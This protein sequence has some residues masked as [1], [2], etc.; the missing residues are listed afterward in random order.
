M[1]DYRRLEVWRLGHE[2]VLTVYRVTAGF[3]DTERYGLTA[4]LRRSA[5]S[6]ASNIAEG[7]GRSSDKE[8][9]RFIDMSLGS[10][11]ECSYQ[12]RLS[13][14]L[15]YLDGDTL[16]GLDERCEKARRKLFNLRRRLLH[17][18]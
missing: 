3:P 1:R 2:L 14:D 9:G 15:G 13:H 4:Q 5:A 17:P 16:E 7:A 6:V 11:A 18:E 8:F 12:L 10:L